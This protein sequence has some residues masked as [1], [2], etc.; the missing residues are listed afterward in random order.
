MTETSLRE[1]SRVSEIVPSP[2]INERSRRLGGRVVIVSDHD[3]RTRRRANMHPVADALV[4]LGCDV[5]F[6]SVRFSVLSRIKGDSRAFLWKRANR[7][8]MSNGVRCYLWRTP[9]HPF[10]PRK[11]GFDGLSIWLYRA[12]ARWPDRFIDD[13]LMEASSVIV[14]SGLGALLLERVRARNPRSTIVYVASDDLETVGVHPFV[15]SQLEKSARCIDQIC[16]PSPKMGPGFAWAGDRIFHVPHGLDRDDFQ[17]DSGSPYASKF[18]AVSVG[19]ML[20]DP[21]VFVRGAA[22]VPDVQFHVIG[23]GMTFDAPPNVRL[24]PEMAFRDTI[25][26]IRHA[27]IGLAPYHMA[28]GC[29]YLCDTSMKLMQYE[30]LGVPAVC[31]LFAVGGKAGRFGYSPGN[32]ETFE[33]AVRA[34][35]AKGRNL[36]PRRFLSWEDVVRRLLDPRAYPDAQM[37]GA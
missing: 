5:T 7:P 33:A 36:S 32:P 20:F 21:D 6:V 1:R 17:D 2:N 34:A 13:A 9:I 35:L 3:Y 30:H 24:Y 15:Q 18:N 16:L 11:P 8:E 10:H 23:A 14:E 27:D 26:F 31:P 22:R 19:S 4:R 37:Q 28:P 25:A 12:Y 29:D